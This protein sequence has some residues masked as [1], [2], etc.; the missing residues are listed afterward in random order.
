MHELPR[1]KSSYVMG[2]YSLR[3]Q[4]LYNLRKVTKILL[5]LF[6]QSYNSSYGVIHKPRGQDE[7]GGW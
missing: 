1:M 4:R 3:T 6:Y 2:L 7:V 5:R